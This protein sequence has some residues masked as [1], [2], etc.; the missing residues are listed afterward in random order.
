MRASCSAACSVRGVGVRPQRRRRGVAVAVERQR[1]AAG[2]ALLAAMAVVEV[3]VADPDVDVEPARPRRRRPRQRT[4]ARGD[5]DARVVGDRVAREVRR[6]G[7]ARQRRVRAVELGAHRVEQRV[8]LDLVG[9][10]GL[11]DVER[12]RGMRRIGDSRGRP[13][14]RGAARPG[15]RRGVCG[16]AAARSDE[17]E[18][19]ATHAASLPHSSSRNLARTSWTDC[20]R[21]CGFSAISAPASAI[22]FSGKM[23]GTGAPALGVL[24]VRQ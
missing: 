14:D 22:S 5:V 21:S 11:D 4:V 7:V 6:V 10:R 8:G 24:E 12:G 20:G 16:R 13:D 3:V 2:R 15:R 17:Q 23:S 18:G 1:R 9:T 19:R